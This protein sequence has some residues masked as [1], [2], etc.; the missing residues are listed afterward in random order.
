MEFVSLG[1]YGWAGD[2]NGLNYRETTFGTSNLITNNSSLGDYDGGGLFS[3]FGIDHYIDSV[4]TLF[5]SF[6]YNRGGFDSNNS[7]TF[8]I[9]D[10]NGNTDNQSSQSSIAD[11][12]WPSVRTNLSY[13]RDFSKNRN[14][15]MLI[16]YAYGRNTGGQSL[17]FT[18]ENSI[19]NGLPSNTIIREEQDV[20]RLGNNHVIR[21]DFTNPYNKNSEIELGAK[22]SFNMNDNDTFASRFDDLAQS[23]IPVDEKNNQYVF[24][25]NVTAGYATIKK[26]YGK[27]GVKTGLRAEHTNQTSE[28]TTSLIE[29]NEQ[30][31]LSLFPSAYLSHEFTDTE[32]MVLSY[33]RR[34]SRPDSRQ[35]NPFTTTPDSTSIWSGNPNLRP[36]FADVLELSHSKNWKTVTLSSAVYYRMVNDIIR[37]TTEVDGDN[38]SRTTSTNYSTSNTK[39]AEV[40]ASISPA[41]WVRIN[42]G[43]NYNIIQIDDSDIGNELKNPTS[44]QLSTNFRTSFTLPA[45]FS[46]QIDGRQ[47]GPFETP[48][49]SQANT[50]RLNAGASKKLFEDKGRLGINMRNILNDSKFE[51]ESFGENFYNLSS[52]QYRGRVFSV[53]F[54]YNFGKFQRTKRKAVRQEE[55]DRGSGGDI[56]QGSGQN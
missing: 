26:K 5:M 44:N 30:N 47:K 3:N 22:A 2:Y 7:N 43:G 38:I 56:E 10:G 25:Q 41:N 40:N 45:K 8:L 6:G 39:G 42:V 29:N 52:N 11:N 32:Q 55:K 51:S 14:H 31:Y 1:N 54:S 36:E 35:L 19:S 48:Q 27:W 23:F 49:G 34:I 28:L 17:G 53:R 50:F 46:L 21:L 24:N 4:N 18:N 16:D 9:A 13:Q 37:R 20:D 15:N 12:R 33:A